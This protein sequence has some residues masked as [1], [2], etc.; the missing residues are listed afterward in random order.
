MDRQ[1]PSVKA[2]IV[3][4]LKTMMKGRDERILEYLCD[5]GITGAKVL[6]P[7]EA[8]NS[9]LRLNKKS[10]LGKRGSVIELPA[11]N[12]IFKQVRRWGRWE[13]EI[14]DFLRGGL[15]LTE[16]KMRRSAL[17]D[18]GAN[19]GLITLQT[20]LAARQTHEFFLFEPLPQ[21]VAAIKRNLGA[22]SKRCHIVPSALSKSAGFETIYTEKRN[23]GNSSVLKSALSNPDHEIKT[24]IET[25]D[26]EAFFHDFGREFGNFVIKS[27][28][29]GM[30]ALILSRIPRH[31][32]DKTSRAVVEV[33]ALP[34]IEG[35]DVRRLIKHWHA[36]GA[37]SWNRELFP[38]IEKEEIEEFWLSKSGQQRNL[39]LER[40]FP[41][42]S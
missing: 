21:H 2:L 36:F 40:K 34:E 35:E 22:M 10:P 17:L 37:I 38:R 3:H 26:T 9:L 14:S 12:V 25:V 31:I 5:L 29:Q 18:I 42:G 11:D 33:W 4:M 28:T 7:T 8:G 6:G 41:Q 39:F 13:P 15:D 23:Y 30:D 19:S 16:S 24:R 1:R 27:D 20:M 32:W